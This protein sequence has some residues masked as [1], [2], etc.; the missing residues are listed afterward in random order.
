[1]EIE[2]R[3]GVLFQ[4]GALFSSLTVAQNIEIP[5]REFLDLPGRLVRALANLKVELVGLKES[6][7][8]EIPRRALRRHDQ[9]RGACPRAGARS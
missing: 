7:G 1:M 6:D 9:A 5:M 3:W 4:F 2:R 8:S